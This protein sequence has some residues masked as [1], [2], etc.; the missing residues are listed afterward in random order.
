PQEVRDCL[1]EETA[2]SMGPL[3]DLYRLTDSVF[4]DDNFNSVL[5]S[6]DMLMLRVHYS[7]ELRSGM[8]E[9]EAAKHV[10]GL[11]AKYNPAGNVSGGV[12]KEISPRVWIAEVE[13]AFGPRGSNGARAA[14]ADRM[15]SIAMAQ[16]WRDGRLAFSYFAKGRALATTQPAAAVASLTA[17][18]RIYR[19][20]PNAQ[21]HV[22][23][24]DMQLSAIALASGQNDQAIAFANRAIPVV[25]QAQ[26]A[27][28]LATLML[29]KAEALENTGRVAEAKALRLDS[30]AWAR[31]GFGSDRQVRG[32]MA[33]IASIGAHGAR[34]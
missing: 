1:N 3:N 5:T 6:F 10:P 16:G 34:G 9:A 21:V 7:P 28:L 24:V 26:N 31:Y 23:H 14:A 32:R 13:R 4:N 22:A 29:I 15:L 27:S 30:L 33:E 25:K 18:A 19:S 17:A 11:L 8:N 12:Y 2:Q 20:L